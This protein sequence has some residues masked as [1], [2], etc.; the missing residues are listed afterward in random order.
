MTSFASC[1]IVFMMA[2]L[3]ESERARKDPSL[4]PIQPMPGYPAPYPTGP[5]GQQPYPTAPYGPGQ[6]PAGPYAPG[7]WAPQPAPG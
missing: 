2:A 7:P 1:F 3:Y 5:Y 4:Y 6:Y